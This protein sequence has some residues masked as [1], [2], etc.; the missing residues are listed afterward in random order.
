MLYG[1][2]VP[3]PPLIV[4]GVGDGTEIPD[5]RAAYEEIASEIDDINPDVLV[6]FSP[7]S[8]MYADY[9]HISPG[10]TGKGDFGS[11]NA[12]QVNFTVEY[13]NELS[14][15]ISETAK[16]ENIDAGFLGERDKNLDWGVTVPLYFF[17]CRKIVRIGLSGFDY[18]THYKFGMC[19]REA[20][21]KLRRKA[22]I[23]ASGDMSHKLGG[24]YGFSEY[25]VKHDNYVRECLEQ[26]DFRK[27]M[28]IDPSVAENAAEC[29]LR[30]IMMLAGAL[31][32]LNVTSKVLSYEAPYGVG[33]LVAAVC[34][35]GKCDSLLPKIISDKDSR[36]K[37]IKE[38]EDDFV[39]LAR[40]NVEHFVRTGKTISLPKDLPKEMIDNKAGVF[41][42]IKKNGNLRG[43]IG[44]TA[45]TTA[46][47]ASEI[48]QNGVS[49][50]S[51]D[52][53]FDP[54][55]PEEL[56]DLTYSVDVLFP[57]EPVD[58]SDKLDVKKY[59]VI[60]SSGYKRGLLLPNLDGVDTIEEQVKIAM[61]KGGIKPT[62]KYSLE[63]F[64]VIRHK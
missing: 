19:I 6:M 46:N 16:S 38:G 64:E 31:D 55:E 28:N 53:R 33:Y 48:I 1:C 60:V 10:K 50:S 47:I 43:C 41:V 34:G 12:P 56:D 52:P 59:G 35:D 51:G 24:S 9:F 63:R 49:A 58:S 18:I 25:G 7:H 14:R 22:V 8:V 20:I 44:T 45:P 39:K 26:S 32:G 40:A 62:D 30:S 36:I 27:L 13:D 37:A 15:L 3:H 21:E 2:L 5:T 11:F 4:P 54:I 61:Q 17:K 29:G 42:S 23:V 57:P